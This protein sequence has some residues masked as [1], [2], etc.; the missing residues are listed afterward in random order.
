M[1][2]SSAF[3]HPTKPMTSSGVREVTCKETLAVYRLAAIITVRFGL[4]ASCVSLGFISSVRAQDA[5]ANKEPDMSRIQFF[6]QRIQPV[7]ETECY[8]CHSHQ[9][10]SVE[11]GLW[12]DSAQGLRIGGDSGPSIVPGDPDQSLLFQAISASEDG[13]PPGGPLPNTTIEHFREWISAGAVDPRSDSLP[14]EHPREPDYSHER[15][16]WAFRPLQLVSPPSTMD[17]A[18]PENAIDFFV[19][20]QMEDAGLAPTTTAEPRQLIRRVFFDL[21][22]LPPTPDEIERFAQNPSAE[23]YAQWIDELLNRPQYGERWAQHWLDVVRYAETE[24]FEYDNTMPGMWRY[25]DYV[26]QSLNEDKPY[27]QFVW[28]QLAGDELEPADQNAL[29]ATGFLR[30]GAVRRNAG[31]QKVASSRN[32]V[33]TERTD[34]IGS[35]ILGLTIGCA[36]C[37]DHKFDPISQY[38]YYRLQA[39]FGLSHENNH[40]LRAAAEQEQLEAVESELDRRITELKEQLEVAE[41]EEEARIRGAIETLESQRPPP[42]PTIC[43]IKNDVQG[44][45]PTYV[46]RRGNPDLPVAEVSMRLPSVLAT[47]EDADAS[48]D[49]PNPRT[50]LANQLLQSQ[51]ALVARVIVNRVWQYHFGQGLVSTPNDLGKNG[52]QASHPE[53]LDYLSLVFVESGWRLKPLHRLILQSQTYRQSSQPA[54]SALSQQIDPDNRLLS[55][56]TRRR[57]SAEEIR[58][59]ML[60]ISGM[61][62]PEMGGPSVILPV[63][64]ELID[65]LYKPSQ[66]QVDKAPEQHARRSIYLFA[67]RN[68]RLP[69]MEVFD[70]PMAQTSCAVRE[71]STHARQA[72]ELVNGQVANELAAAFAARLV[73]ASGG[74]P[75]RIVEQAFQLTA[76]RQAWPREQQLSLEF[77]QQA[78][79]REF[80]LAMFSFN[81]FLYVD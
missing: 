65:Q 39:F 29:I 60:A 9:A 17:T 19:L 34:A 24:G 78:G 1:R 43:G 58:D 6:E 54:D 12:L 59:A 15:D 4:V 3:N 48:W 23:A 38:D 81:G 56:F 79:P 53:L 27:D 13:M 45:S 11:G 10:D 7:L 44:S 21:I 57:L 26:I 28:E 71:E 31:N 41:G 67:K 14:S 2:T 40:S 32:E 69:F 70:Q 50:R 77:L 66:W 36:R 64:Q 5:V 62:N 33:L 68:L 22:G 52:S 55:H 63:E 30:L 8:A 16:Y 72:L 37:H 74:D 25:R 47:A 80:A 73:S 20:K 75:N 61:L 18:W 49:I 76:G 35:A 51:Q 42:G 46:L